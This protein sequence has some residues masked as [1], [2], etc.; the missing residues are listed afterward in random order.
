[1]QSLKVFQVSRVLQ[2]MYHGECRIVIYKW[3][4]LYISSRLRRFIK[5]KPRPSHI[6]SCMPRLKSR[7]INY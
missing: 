1:M 3:D 6:I 5:S 2:I 4:K 7:V